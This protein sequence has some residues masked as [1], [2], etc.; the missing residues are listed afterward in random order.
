MEFLIG[1]LVLVVGLL[2]SIALHELG[3]MIPAKRFGVLVSEYFVGFGPRLWS[4]RKGETEYGFKAIP[5][6]G[7]VKL[8]GMV[9]PAS[10]VKPLRLGGWAGRLIDDTRAQAEEEIPAGQDHRA[11]YH[12]TWWR[13]AIVMMGGP[14]VNLVIAVVLFTS[15]LSFVGVP[16]QTLAVAQ[17]VQCVPAAGATECATGDPVAPAAAAGIEAGDVFVS[18]DGV[19]LGSWTDLTSYV[20]DRP[21]QQIALVV[22]R[23]G[24]DVSLT[25]TP[26]TRTVYEYDDSGAVV[27]DAAGDPVTQQVGYLGVYSLT[28]SQ[29]QPLWA[30]ASLTWDYLG[31]TAGVI[32]HL[33]Q[34][35]YHVARAALGLEER[36][37]DSVMGV[38]GV[39]RISGEIASANIDGYT[40]GER[41]T[42]MMMLLAGLN[43][44]LFAF[45]MIP[46]V[47][48][49]GGHVV[50]A[51]WQGIKN[52]W[53]RLRGLA[54]P[55]PVDVARMMP[56]AYGV[57]ALLLVMGAVLVYA[58][59]VAPVTIA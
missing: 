17:V 42:D 8:V 49:D 41:I 19:A 35:V 53:A 48:L 43:L 34:Q 11:F 14:V 58:D 55:R 30:G 2:V 1:V 26:A 39:G 59:I 27:T 9:P 51:L 52:G 44:A 15:V 10:A 54:A 46:L 5:L 4:R 28:E 22:D 13:K 18:A 37:T 25:V 21:G 3:H 36:T 12:L 38:V 32:V 33:P 40:L 6:G 23:S 47:P 20:A 24:E 7:Y 56:L 50:S 29:R 16:T 45:N 31:Q 57:F